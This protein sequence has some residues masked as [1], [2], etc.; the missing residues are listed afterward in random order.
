MKKPLDELYFEWLYR[1][2]ASVDQKNTSKT[3]WLLLREFY[4][5]EFIWIVPNDINRSED[6]KE[7]RYEFVD[8]L[9]LESV[10]IDWIEL[11]CSMLELTIGLARRLSFEVEGE[12]R[13]WFWHLLANVHLDA[14]NDKNP[15]PPHEIDEILDDIIWRNYRLDGK[16]GFFPL[17]SPNENQKRV[18]LWYQMSAYILENDLM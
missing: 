9:E 15:R 8:A 2:V 11:G 18:E 3:F 16:G 1:Q 17:R 10:D 4:K 6:G 12:P 5:K 14:S 13:R 7:L